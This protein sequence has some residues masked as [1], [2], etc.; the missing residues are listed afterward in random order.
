MGLRSACRPPSATGAFPAALTT[1]SPRA[2]SA[3]QRQCRMRLFKQVV[4]STAVPRII[5]TGNR[6]RRN[7]MT[8]RSVRRRHLGLATL[9]AALWQGSGPGGS[10]PRN[11]FRIFIAIARSRSGPLRLRCRAGHGV[12]MAIIR[13]QVNDVSIGKHW[14]GRMESNPQHSAREAVGTELC[15]I[16]VPSLIVVRLKGVE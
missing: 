2:A 5:T 14:S 16:S 11:H 3:G 10:A 4:N 6:T 12:L 13:Q 7:L 9:A 15:L 8:C 1:G